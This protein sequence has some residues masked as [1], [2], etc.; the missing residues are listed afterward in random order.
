MNGG[1]GTSSGGDSSVGGGGGT[2]LGAVVGLG[3]TALSAHFQGKAMRKALKYTKRIYLN[4]YTWTVRDLEQAGINPMLAA[5]GALGGG[6]PGGVSAAPMPANTLADSAAKGASTAI[7]M[8]RQVEEL[9]LLRASAHKQ[10]SEV[11]RNAQQAGLAAAQAKL[12][13]TENQLKTTAIPAAQA[14]EK[15]DKTEA[16]GFLRQINRVIRSITGRDQTS[17]R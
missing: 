2:A 1:G 9:K 15:L 7:A 3:G 10:T 6:G 11:H 8:K 5:S 12:T 13:M 17:A 14:Q 16:G 4:R